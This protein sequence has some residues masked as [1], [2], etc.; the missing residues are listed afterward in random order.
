MIATPQGYLNFLNYLT[1][2]FDNVEDLIALIHY[3]DNTYRLVLANEAFARQVGQPVEQLQDKLV[4]EILTTAQFAFVR[5]Y[6]ERVRTLRQPQS[7]EYSWPDGKRVALVTCYPIE[8]ALDEPVYLVAIGQT[9]SGL[10]HEQARRRAVEAQLALLMSATRERLLVVDAGGM[11]ELATGDWF[12]N[13]AGAWRGQAFDA[14]VRLKDDGGFVQ[15]FPTLPANGRTVEAK[16]M[17]MRPDGRAVAVTCELRRESGDGI[18][19]PRV[20]VVV[21]EAVA[22]V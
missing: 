18:A 8:N 22:R 20:A 17:V 7:F 13:E 1:T 10:R 15:L 21:R 19:A 6:Y 5:Q 9:I 12:G 16:A 2:V 14:V 11:I 4:S 3:E